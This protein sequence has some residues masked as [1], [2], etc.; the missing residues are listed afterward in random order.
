MWWFTQEKEIFDTYGVWKQ[1]LMPMAALCAP[2][3]LAALTYSTMLS[4]YKTFTWQW[5]STVDSYY[6]YTETR[7]WHVPLSSPD[8]LGLP[9][10]VC[11]HR[12]LLVA[13]GPN[14]DDSGMY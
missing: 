5:L 12:I 13:A 9:G 7:M 1:H 10:P 3:S 2:M 8:C 6:A 11:T 4:L 14:E